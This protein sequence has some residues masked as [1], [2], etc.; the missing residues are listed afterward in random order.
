MQRAKLRS[1]KN[2]D[3]IRRPLKTDDRFLSQDTKEPTKKRSSL[4]E[5]TLTE[6]SL[7]EYLSAFGSHL[8][9]LL[10]D[11]PHLVNGDIV[12]TGLGLSTSFVK[13][14]QLNSQR[15]NAS[16]GLLCVRMLALIRCPLTQ[17]QKVQKEL[18]AMITNYAD[19]QIVDH[20]NQVWS[21][22]LA[23]SDSL[24]IT[25]AEVSVANIVRIQEQLAKEE[26]LNARNIGLGTLIAY[27]ARFTEQQHQRHIAEMLLSLAKNQKTN[28][29]TKQMSIETQTITIDR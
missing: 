6:K 16:F 15:Y 28:T 14:A 18:A 24:R 19:L 21:T 22:V 3:W 29:K 9:L 26:S 10:H 27:E 20:Y 11:Q 7:K 5:T 1:S 13:Q 25:N 4:T 2:D 12:L 8:L 17:Q 23:V